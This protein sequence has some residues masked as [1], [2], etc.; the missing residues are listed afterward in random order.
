MILVRSGPA[1]PG[2]VGQAQAGYGQERHGYNI[3]LSDGRE[4]FHGRAVLAMAPLGSVRFAGALA[5]CGKANT[6]PEQS[7]ERFMR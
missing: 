5:G 7:G 6:S 1:K 2:V 4:R 3:P